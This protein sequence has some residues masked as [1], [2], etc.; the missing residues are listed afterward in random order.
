MCVFRMTS[1]WNPR[2]CFEINQ[3][4]VSHL[5]GHRKPSSDVFVDVIAR[6]LDLLLEV[7][8][9]IP[10]NLGRLNVIISQTVTGIV[11]ITIAST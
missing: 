11:M 1:W 6:D 5:V 9:S 10:V 3:P 8:D 7:K 2:K 4:F